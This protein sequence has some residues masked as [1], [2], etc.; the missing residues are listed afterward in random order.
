MEKKDSR[1]EKPP[2]IGTKEIKKEGKTITDRDK[3]NQER[4]KNHCS[5]AAEPNCQRA[6]V[7][8]RNKTK[9]WSGGEE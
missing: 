1:T 6:G 7:E 5:R 4:R 9:R 3:R 8:E 2:Q